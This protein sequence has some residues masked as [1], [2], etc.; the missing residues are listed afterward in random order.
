[1]QRKTDTYTRYW[2][3]ERVLRTVRIASI[4][5]VVVGI[6]NR[7]GNDVTGPEHGRDQFIA[8]SD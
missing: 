5:V 3:P 7:T 6:E 4:P 1:M 8:V 2:L